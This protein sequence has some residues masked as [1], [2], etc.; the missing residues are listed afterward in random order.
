[1]ALCCLLYKKSNGA[2]IKR[3]INRKHMKS[4]S[5]T[6]RKEE[7]KAGENKVGNKKQEDGRKKI[8]ENK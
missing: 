7:K 5:N 6:R 3:D 8:E 4:Y 2:R 1:M